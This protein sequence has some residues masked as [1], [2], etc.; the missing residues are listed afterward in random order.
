MISKRIVLF[1]VLLSEFIFLWL[2][3][4][5]IGAVSLHVHNFF[6]YGRLDLL[7]SDDLRG[8]WF[9]WFWGVIQSFY[10]KGGAMIFFGVLVVGILESILVLRCKRY[11]VAELLTIHQCVLSLQVLALFGMV[12][13]AIYVLEDA[14]QL[15][16]STEMPFHPLMLV[17]CGFT[18]LIPAAAQV[19]LFL[20]RRSANRKEIP[21][22]P[23]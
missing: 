9:F 18:W 23:R 4:F 19:L 5:S 11:S 2:A 17:I 16:M 20:I 1:Y 8:F 21:D 15:L 22:P 6:H 3:F 7:S 10:E 14:K 13:V 12:A